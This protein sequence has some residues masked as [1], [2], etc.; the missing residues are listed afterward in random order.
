[1]VEGEYLD[2]SRVEDDGNKTIH[3]RK[4]DVKPIGFFDIEDNFSE[5]IK[6]LPMIKDPV[7]LASDE[8]IKKIFSIS[9][10]SNNSNFKNRKTFK[11]RN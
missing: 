6:Y 1:M 9:I 3:I 11:R 7:Y 5:G 8:Q 10:N 4:V 2:E